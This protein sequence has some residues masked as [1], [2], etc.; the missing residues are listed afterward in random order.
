MDI[1]PQGNATSGFGIEKKKIENTS[2]DML[3]GEK[4][5]EQVILHTEFAMW[6]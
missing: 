1:D 5:A 3:I 4:T 6:T 2:Y